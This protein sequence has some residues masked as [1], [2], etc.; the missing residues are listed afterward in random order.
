LVVETVEMVVV[1]VVM[2]AKSIAEYI[3]VSILVVAVS[4]VV[5]GSASSKEVDGTFHMH[6]VTKQEAVS[7]AVKQGMH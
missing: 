6:S 5:T 4:I 7:F 3:A 2:N 1:S